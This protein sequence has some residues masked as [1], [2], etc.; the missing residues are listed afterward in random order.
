[1]GY[2]AGSASGNDSELS[3]WLNRKI[4]SQVDP[5]KAPANSSTEK[6]VVVDEDSAVVD[7]V[8]KVSPSVV[9]IIVTKDLPKINRFNRPFGSDFFRRFFGDDEFNDFFGSDP[10]GTRDGGTEK[11][12]VGGGTGFIVSPDG[13]IVTNK[14]VVNDANAEYTVLMNN[15]KRYPA[16]VLAK[17][18]LADR[19]SVV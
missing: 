13:Y 14:H 7:A 1:M 8:E 4:M 18:N 15:E 10:G 3:R 17:D 5:E 2:L 12:E 6:V 16:K 11:M 9:S 19:K